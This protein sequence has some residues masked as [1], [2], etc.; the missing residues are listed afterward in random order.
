MKHDPQVAEHRRS[1]GRCR[2][3]VGRARGGR[4]GLAEGFC[5]GCGHPY[6]FRPALAPGTAVASQYEVLGP[7]AH[8]GVGWVYLAR[9]THLDHRYVVLKGLIDASDPGLA[10]VERRALTT[11][12]HRD[13]VRISDFVSHP[14]ERTGQSR[15]YIVMEYVDGLSLGEI[16]RAGRFGAEPLRV[17]HVLTCVRHVLEAFEYLH[18]RGFL[19]CDMKPDN[20]IV[21]PGNRGEH[22]SRVKLIDLGAVRRIGDRSGAIIGTPGYQV[23]RREI[24][25]RGLT[26]DT[27]LYT[28]GRMMEELYRVSEDA[29]RTGDADPLAIGLESFR[30]LR[31]RAFHSD[32]DRRFRSARA[33]LD[34]LDGVH[35]EVASLRDGEPR[36]ERSRLF[37][38]TGVLLDA[39]LG[40]VPPLARW[41]GDGHRGT[42][43]SLPDGRP[44][45]GAVAV[46]LPVPRVDPDDEAA[47][48]VGAVVAAGASDPR[49]L[50]A[51]LA[52]VPDTVEARYA[53]FRAHLAVGG[54]TPELPDV[55]G[56]DRDGWRSSWHRGLLALALG[57]VKRAA[58]AFDAVYEA[59]PGEDAPKL[60][61]G[62]CAEH[63][64]ADRR[65]EQLYEAVWRRDPANGSAAFGLV[66]L[67][68]GR[69]DRAGA[70]A[71]LDGVP[72]VARHH[73][74]A[75]VAAVS[76]LC[77]HLGDTPPAPGDLREAAYRLAAL[78]LDGD[79]S[80][81]RLTAVVREAAFDLGDP[82]A[83]YPGEVFGARPDVPGLRVLLE[84]SYRELSRQ[85][86]SAR[87]HGVLVDLANTIRPRTAR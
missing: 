16:G 66:R 68:L 56:P 13:I 14:D 71:V 31:E 26:V 30:R 10:A 47:D 59:V 63:A 25:E 23:D 78:Y 87:A 79:E 44:E 64:G 57:D 77:G 55:V 48:V 75:R 41:T 51:K 34:Q 35:R 27:D 1:C 4:P 7:F 82:D 3:P 86:R 17:E 74:A 81:T 43:D 6:S 33:L 24:D 32:P 52:T 69:G 45:P 49:R 19:Y 11:L 28:V 42:G 50:V 85:A 39:G 21:R 46:G 38:P 58:S 40:A 80:R 8:G 15:D 37:A 84:Q 36:P 72:T 2:E 65:A 5:H 18:D 62:Y 70:V 83:L 20:V 61:L 22:E 54:T 67:R 29:A 12:D 73:D 76:V 9:D 60:A 53:R